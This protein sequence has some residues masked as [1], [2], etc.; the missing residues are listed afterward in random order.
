MEVFMTRWQQIVH[1]HQHSTWDR[2][3]ECHTGDPINQRG[4][5]DEESRI[6]CNLGYYG[7]DVKAEHAAMLEDGKKY[8][9]S[10]P[11]AV[12]Y[13]GM[14]GNDTDEFDTLEEAKAHIIPRLQWTESDTCFMSDYA[15]YYLVGFKLSD[16]GVKWK[17]RTV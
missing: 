2:V 11:F 13:R 5:T 8:R 12:E 9:S 3:V 1:D 4:I 6:I 17:D 10:K 7:H 15:R 16:I 14:D